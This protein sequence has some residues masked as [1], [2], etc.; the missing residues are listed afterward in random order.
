M[1]GKVVSQW[2]LAWRIDVDRIAYIEFEMRTEDGEVV[3]GTEPGEPVPVRLGRGDV[4]RDFEEAI[5]SLQPGEC[6]DVVIP[7]ERAFGFRDPSMIRAV[8]R[9]EFPDGVTPEAGMAF[10]FED[11]DGTVIQFRIDRIEGDDVWCDFNH[12]LAG[13]S[14]LLHVDLIRFENLLITP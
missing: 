4:P 3:G 6:T 13:R 12:P 9:S 1:I 7:P 2:G 10:A 8:P 5:L 11:E 14:I